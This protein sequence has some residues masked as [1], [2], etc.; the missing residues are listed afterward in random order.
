VRYVVLAAGFDGT[1]ARD[2]RCD[3]RSIAALRALAASGRKLILVTSRELRDLLDVFPEARLFDYLVA[4]NGAVVHRPSSR[5]S[6][7]LAQAPSETLIHELR[8]RRVTPLSVGSVVVTTSNSHSETLSEVVQ[9][10]RLDSYVL[11]NGATVAVLPIGVNKA[12]GVLQV[13][14]ELGLSSHNL[15]SIGDAENDIALFEM[16]EHAV[17]VANASTSLKHIA[18]RI[19]RASYADGV[20]ELAQELMETDLASAPTRRRIVI[21]TRGGQNEVTLPT[22]HCS[23]LLSG[24]AASG[25]AALCNSVLSQYLTQHYQCCIIGAYATRGLVECEGVQVC[26]DEQSSPR[27]AEIMGALEHPTQSVIVNL[28]SLRPASRA[29]FAE[30]LL[31]RLASMQAL[32]GRPHAIVFDQAE[33]LLSAGALASSEQ[34]RGAMRIYVTAQPDIL[35]REVRQ[36]VEV[37][38]ALGDAS[39]TLQ[40]VQSGEPSAVTEPGVTALEPG[41]AMLWMRHSGTSPCKVELDLRPAI[42]RLIPEPQGA[43][44]TLSM[45]RA[46]RL[47]NSEAVVP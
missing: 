25:K 21:G 26:G 22:A 43:A 12:T 16:S 42:F 11:D 24:P 37:V 9:K 41:Q 10:L 18:D 34:L 40:C 33:G 47:E 31:E 15:V 45:V 7:I 28:V 29:Q 36:S 17:A 44:T 20:A 19:T 35:P 3:E 23:I 14:E 39:A 32:N 6:A 5:E 13:L 30:H 1:L 46:A 4:E 8:R 38:L 2:G 27:H